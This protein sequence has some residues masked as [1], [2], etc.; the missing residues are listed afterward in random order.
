MKTRTKLLSLVI[1]VFL[2]LIFPQ[3]IFAEYIPLGKTIWMNLSPATNSTLGGV[4][5][6]SCPVNEF[7]KGVF[8]NGTLYCGVI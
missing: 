4:F 7:V 8:E 2:I 6:Q 5:S 1:G 3:N